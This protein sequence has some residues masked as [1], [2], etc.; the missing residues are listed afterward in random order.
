MN[1][2][3]RY[4]PAEYF[5]LRRA[6]L[7]DVLAEME[8]VKPGRHSNRP[9]YRIYSVDRKHYKEISEESKYWN[10]AEKISNRR[11]KLTEMLKNTETVISLLDPR[12]Y[13]RAMKVINKT[14]R[15]GN[16]FFDSLTDGSCPTDNNTDYH[17][18]GRHFRSRSEMMFAE[19]LDEL[20][21]EYKYDVSIRFSDKTV[22]IDFVIVFREY[23]R[24]VFVE[25]FG[26]SDDPDYNRRNSYKTE[27]LAANGIYIGRDLF[28]LSGDSNYT[29]GIE[30]IRIQ[31]LAIIALLSGYHLRDSDYQ[32]VKY[33]K[34]VPLV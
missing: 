13:V 33:K 21:L 19:V 31:I 18:N 7:K 12:R 20:G 4:I 9:V 3:Y 15:Y 11:I 32:S 25:Y 23:N 6:F 8:V 30:Q 29:P 17:S 27:Q 16:D 28:I 22:T 10:A 24:C 1:D 26:R 2:Q 5:I 34:P 14:N